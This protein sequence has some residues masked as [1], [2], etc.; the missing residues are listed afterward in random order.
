MPKEV[1]IVKAPK[2]PDPK[3]EPVGWL[4]PRT[5]AELLAAAEHPYRHVCSHLCN[6][7]GIEGVHYVR[8]QMCRWEDG[9]WQSVAKLPGIIPCARG[10]GRSTTTTSPLGVC[11][12][13]ASIDPELGGTAPETTTWEWPE[14]A[15]GFLTH[16]RATDTLYF[17]PF[18]DAFEVAEWQSAHPEVPYGG[19]LRF[20]YLDVDWR[21]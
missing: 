13:C 8:A 6:G 5:R 15:V 2:W 20:M 16:S 18:A 12:D 19:A 4:E 7:T 10:C 14:G 1:Q 17:G 21:R 3:P 11:A 9:R